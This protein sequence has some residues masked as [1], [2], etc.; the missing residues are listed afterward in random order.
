MKTEKPSGNTASEEGV[1][2]T[3][4]ANSY[5]LGNTSLPKTDILNAGEKVSLKWIFLQGNIIQ[6]I[7]KME[8]KKKKQLWDGGSR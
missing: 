2:D 7:L 4:F 5:P 3:H 6:N 1:I 8:L